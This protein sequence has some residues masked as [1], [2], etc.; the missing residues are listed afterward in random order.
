MDTPSLPEVI[1]GVKVRTKAAEAGLPIC[2]V[3]DKEHGHQSLG[4]A[5]ASKS[6]PCVQ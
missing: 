6:L 4:R 2:Q 3:L 1:P 5:V